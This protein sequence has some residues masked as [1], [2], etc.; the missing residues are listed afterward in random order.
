MKRIYVFV[1]ILLVIN[2]LAFA[3]GMNSKEIEL[4]FN[5]RDANKSNPKYELLFYSNGEKIAKRV[6]QNGK[7]LVVEGKI[8]DGRVVERYSSG[9]VKNIFIYVD[10]KRNGKALSF[11]KSGKLKKESTYLDDN[12]IG[13]TKMYY[14]SGSL[15]V[16]SKIADGKNI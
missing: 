2:S 4:T 13:I 15:K 10:S 12:P 5:I 1:I 3:N 11:Y 8:P 9:K 16:E 6:Y 14:E 7:T